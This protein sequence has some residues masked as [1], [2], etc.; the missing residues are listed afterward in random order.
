MRLKF[1][2]RLSWFPRRKKPRRLRLEKSGRC[3]FEQLESREMLSFTHPGGLL[4]LT[5]LD[6]MKTQ[7]AAGAHPWIDDWNVLITDSQAQ[8]TYTA[9]AQANM[10]ANR[11]RADADAHAAYLN[12]I[13]WYISGDTRFANCAVNILNAW[14]AAVNQV[15]TGT[16]IPGL[17][18]IPIFDFALAGEV[19]R[20]YSGWAPAD[21]DRFKNMMTA[22]LYPVVDD[23]LDNHR[24]AAIDHYWSNWDAANLGAKIAMGVLL[25]NQTIFD[26]GVAYYQSGAGNGS[27][28]HAVYYVHPGNLGQWQESG[29]DQEHAQL[30]VGLLATAAQV[31]WN[32]GVDL[33]G[34][35]GNR[36]LMGAEY[37]AQTNLSKPVPYTTYNNSDNVKQYYISIN[38]IGR[39]DDRPVWELIYNHYV[40]LQGLSAPNVQA[41]AQLMRPEHGSADHFGYGTLTFT[42]SAAASPYPPSPVAPAPTGLTA[43]AGVGQ[44]MLKWNS[45]GDTAQ[46]YRIQRATASGGPYTTIASWTANTTPEYTDTSVTNGTTY[47]Y[48]VAANN[49]SGTSANSSQA[50]AKPVASGALPAGWAQRDIGAVN[51]AGSATFASVS[52]GAFVVTGNGNDI[53]GTA[54]SFSYAYKSVS[55]N[56]TFVARLLINGS[57]K[58]GL[59]MRETLDANSKAV[60]ITLG[61]TGGRETKMRTR[62]STGGSMSTQTGNAYTWTPVWYKLQRSGNTF[63]AYQSLDGVT[64]FMV[65]SSTVSMANTYY[66][67]LAVCASTATFDNV[68]GPPAAPGD[69]TAAGGNAQV[70]LSWSPMPDAIGYNV[71]RAV[72]SGGPYA[73]VGPGVT[74]SNFADSEVVN[75]RTYFYVVAAIMPGGGETANSAEA[76]AT[77]GV[78]VKLSGTIIGTSGSWGNNPATTKE[79]A[80]DGSLTTFYDAVHASGD[81]VGL[82]L[83][84]P[85][86][87]TQVK[88]CPRS[89]YASRMVGGQFQA[90]NAADF[91]SGVVTLFTI[92][93]TP[94]TGVLTTQAISDATPYRYVRYLGPTGGYC[95]VAE[96]EFYGNILAPLTSIAGRMVFYNN[97]KFDGHSSY[98]SGDPAANVYDDNAIAADKTAL[99]PGQTATFSNYTSFSRGINGVMVDIQNLANPTGLSANDFQFQT[100]NGA[101]WTTAPA[102]ASVSVRQRQGT[103]GSD[104]VTIIWDDT[105]GNS[106]TNQWLQVTVLANGNTGLSANDVFY[107]GNA[108]GESGD[109]PANALVDQLDEIASRTHKTGFT[110]AGITNP[111]DY[112]RDGKVNATDD[113]I[114]RNNAAVLLQLITAPVGAPLAVMA[115]L[116]P[117]HMEPEVLPADAAQPA[118]PLA[119]TTGVQPVVSIEAVQP[120]QA[121][122]NPAIQGR[123]SGKSKADSLLSTPALPSKAKWQ[124]VPLCHSASSNQLPAIASRQMV[125]ISRQSVAHPS[126]PIPY[127]PRSNLHAPAN[128]RQHDAVFAR[129][130][131]GRQIGYEVTFRSMR[132]LG[133]KGFEELL[134]A[135]S[136]TVA[137]Q[138][139]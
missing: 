139:S 73:I 38:G 118:E 62:S 72:A 120:V 131:A 35:A 63:T 47:Y 1:E 33:Y 31:A 66:V 58:V 110:A 18:G 53:G 61:E 32:Q 48:V 10:G 11:Q 71:K 77:P 99:L 102:P 4:T 109:D 79:A 2:P 95:N 115:V 55:G 57:N 114:A 96:V 119:L 103:D 41:M 15:P 59:M 39:L 74:A 122:T 13:R 81:W 105:T 121:D 124:I 23:F 78:N 3:R 134:Q 30:A 16:D 92:S 75:G 90:S 65:G 46:G 64:W 60:T 84:T 24:G 70:F 7:V 50:S 26:E 85:T 40:V 133:L 98:A 8:Y 44:V 37:V 51:S 89:G 42:L 45:S 54:D 86:T 137:N 104:R 135:I 6:R 129:L 93:S 12:T 113:L 19:L 94:T 83:G 69:L 130:S 56:Y 67:G 107:F 43:T 87:I 106:I 34:Y 88:Y 101:G 25:D 128:A 29:R 80:M 117:L 36:L 91:S 136:V 125:G 5:D 138:T 111:Y 132:T 17:I 123:E 21:F 82:D 28:M 76:S 22:Y 97:S 49:Q 52:N 9:A 100:G 14:S 112:S 27:I 116:Q 126:S 68:V 20:T 108:V 127:P